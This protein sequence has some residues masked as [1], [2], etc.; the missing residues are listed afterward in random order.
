M[1]GQMSP[2][3]R[4]NKAGYFGSNLGSAFARCRTAFLGVGLF[5]GA[6]NILAL[7]GSLYMLQLY[8]RV[9]PAHSVPTLVGLTIIMLLL[10][11]GFG[12]F[13]LLRT[14]MMIRI[15][16]RIERNLRDRV[17]SAVLLLPLRTI[18]G[19][20][21]LQPVRDLEQIRGFL[22]G[23]GP[24]ALFDLPWIPFYLGLVYV[25]HPWLGMLG[26]AG[27]VILL[28]LTILTEARSRRPMRDAAAT[29]AARYSFGE[30]ARRNAE[31]VRALGMGSRFSQLWT[32]LNERH[33][34]HLVGAA[35]AAGTYGSIC[36]ALRMA[37]QSAVL[38]L[39]AYLV[40]QGQATAGVM[41]A[42]WRRICGFWVW[43]KGADAVPSPLHSQVRKQLLR[44]R[45]L[46]QRVR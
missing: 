14:R 10:Y 6:I 5:S 23:T 24:T 26:L 43:G 35:D 37:L 20:D 3:Y 21:G 19:G 30:A 27:A 31:I 46:C 16:V 7:T 12:V 42:E 28:A 1:T 18:P 15:G 38:G 13:D 25:L 17:F 32:S 2:A 4:A 34:V 44:A 39:G 45:H 36:K 22:S 11:M 9:L 8:D 29:N 33:L 41:I 40:I